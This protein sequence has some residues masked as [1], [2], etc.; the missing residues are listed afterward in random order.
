M[1]KYVFLICLILFPGFSPAVL[2][3]ADSGLE[4]HFIDVGMGDSM[5]IDLP[6][7]SNILVDAGGPESG[8]GL[9][10]YLKGEGVERIDRLIFTHPHDDH[11]GGIF[12]LLS[13]FKVGVFYDNGFSNFKSTIYGPYL[14]H[15]RNDLSKYRVLQ[16]GETL[17]F[18]GVNIEVINPLLPPAG[19]LN[20]DSIVL[21]VCYGDVSVLLAGDIGVSSERRLLYSGIE[22][23][24]DVLKVGHHGSE[25]ASSEAFL[26]AVGARAAVI[27]AGADNKYARPRQETLKRLEAAGMKIYRTDQD[28]H[29]VLKTDGKEFSLHT[30]KTLNGESK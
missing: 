3:A 14:K 5:L 30:E 19:K 13:E 16:A 21:R 20:A 25:K 15:V 7:G 12:N 27:N 24:S 1:R 28:G 11:I 17:S 4:L 18:G 23:K 10:R 29:V 9:V 8:P 2:P 26:A 6:D 22:L